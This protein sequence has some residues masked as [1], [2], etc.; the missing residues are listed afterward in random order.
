MPVAVELARVSLSLF[1]AL[2]PTSAA[3]NLGQT[4]ADTV[5]GLFCQDKNE[6]ENKSLCCWHI[7]FT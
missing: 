5:S 1:L 3:L 2:M 7:R 6:G 4:K